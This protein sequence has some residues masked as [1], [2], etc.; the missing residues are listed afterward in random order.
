MANLTTRKQPKEK[1]L[2]TKRGHRKPSM[3]PDLDLSKPPGALLSQ[4]INMSPASESFS[5]S[6]L[7]HP[8]SSSAAGKANGVTSSSLKPP[9]KPG[10]AFDIYC[11]QM[12][13]VL[14]DKD[15][16]KDDP[17]FDV[18]AELARGWKDL[19]EKES[20]EFQAQYEEDLKRYQ[21]DK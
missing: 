1:P 11:R 5:Q 8:G 7:A 17:D 21:K 10:T 9:R 20:E 4:S 15:K 2:R 19:P 14:L 13:P 18:D 12:R 16:D 3:I 6:Q